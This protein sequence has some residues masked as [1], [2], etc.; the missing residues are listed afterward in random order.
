MKIYAYRLLTSDDDQIGY[1]GVVF[2]NS[3]KQLFWA[4]DEFC[5]PYRCEIKELDFSSAI[6]M[7]YNIEHDEPVTDRLEIGSGILDT[8]L[9]D[10]DGWTLAFDED[11][12]VTKPVRRSRDG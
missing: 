12:D 8:V 9:N 1:F 10:E 3:K 5:D 4:L 6:C 11:Y 2:A 7:A